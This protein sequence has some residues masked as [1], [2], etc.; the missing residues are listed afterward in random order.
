[1]QG[2]THA[3]LPTSHGWYEFTVVVLCQLHKLLHKRA[4]DDRRK[5]TDKRIVSIIN[6]CINQS[7]NQTVMILPQVHLRKPCYDFY[8]L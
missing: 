2:Q 5:T 8:F 6:Q 1:M 3:A 4:T 7:I